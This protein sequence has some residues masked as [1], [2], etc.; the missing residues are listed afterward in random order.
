MGR[1]KAYVVVRLVSLA[2][3]GFFY[4]MRRKRADPKITMIRYDPRVKSMVL[5]SEKK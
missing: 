2:G 3:T 1:K 5:F 4:S